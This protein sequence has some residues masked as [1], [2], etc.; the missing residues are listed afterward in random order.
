MIIS[1]TIITF[2]LLTNGLAIPTPTKKDDKTPFTLEEALYLYGTRSF[3]SSWISGKKK[4][5]QPLNASI[6]VTLKTLGVM[7]RVIRRY[8]V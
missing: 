6:Y 7:I 2:G 1:I 8:G 4:A 3:A 5:N